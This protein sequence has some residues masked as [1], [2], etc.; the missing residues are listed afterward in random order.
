MKPLSTAFF[1][2]L[3]LFCTGCN[4]T[5]FTPDGYGTPPPENL[6]GN[7]VTIDDEMVY[8]S[9]HDGSVD[10]TVQSHTRDAF[11]WSE[12]LT[13]TSSV[14]W[15]EISGPTDEVEPYGSTTFNIKVYR[16]G[17]EPG[18]YGEYLTLWYNDRFMQ[19]VNVVVQVGTPD[20]APIGV[21]NNY[22]RIPA[23]DYQYP[24]G[25]FY[26]SDDV[27]DHEYWRDH[28]RFE[29]SEHWMVVGAV[30]FPIIP[31][32]PPAYFIDIQRDGLQPGLYFGHL[33]IYWDG[34]LAQIIY[35]EMEVE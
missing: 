33:D 21:A 26:N 25:I 29:S 22:I 31:P 5:P 19:Y 17:L 11:V 4:D 9:A 30:N 6:D 2:L 18:S 32:I 13:V 12:N 35:V 3:L 27:E 16:E 28:L 8:V 24:I 23:D 20:A 14:D 7:P 1:M 15:I 10:V 34:D